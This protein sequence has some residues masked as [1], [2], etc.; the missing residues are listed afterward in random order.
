MALVV[1]DDRLAAAPD[2]LH[3]TVDAALLQP[4]GGQRQDDLHRHVLA[5]AE[6]P[7]DGRVA[8]DDL[9]LRQA[10]RVGDLLAVLV[11]PLAGHDHDDPPQRV[12][13]AQPRFRLQVGMLLRASA[14]GVF[15]HHVGAAAKAAST[16]PRRT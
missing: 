16:S 3:W 9:L 5:A 7:A 12:D 4:P 1:A 15:H 6:R 13:V 11:Y 8:H 14:V 10:Q 2:R